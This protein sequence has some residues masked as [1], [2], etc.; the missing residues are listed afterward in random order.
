MKKITWLGIVG[1][2]GMVGA[3]CAESDDTAAASGQEV[4]APRAL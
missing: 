3:G 2:A 1:M 4:R